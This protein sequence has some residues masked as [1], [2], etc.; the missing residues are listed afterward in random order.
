VL[1]L[2]LSDNDLD[3]TSVNG[4]LTTVLASGITTGEIH[5]GGGTSAAPTGAGITAADDLNT[6]GVVVTANGYTYP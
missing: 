2:D 4:I 5:L 1:R 6:L 3:V